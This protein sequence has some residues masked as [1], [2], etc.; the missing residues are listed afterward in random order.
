[1]SSE[2]FLDFRKELFRRCTPQADRVRSSVKLEE[3]DLSKP[4]RDHQVRRIASQP[5]SGDPVLSDIEGIRQ[6]RSRTPDADRWPR[7]ERLGQAPAMCSQM[8][9]QRR[10]CAVGAPLL[11]K[12]LPRIRRRTEAA[13]SR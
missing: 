3:A 5:G 1:M 9:M 12:P 11:G 8:R 7:V 4:G 10:W 2:D 13:S 6:D